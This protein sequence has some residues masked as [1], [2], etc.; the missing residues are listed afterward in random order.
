MISSLNKPA[1]S[2]R[3]GPWEASMQQSNKMNGVADGAYRLNIDRLEVLNERM[4]ERNVPSSILQQQFSQ[5]PVSTKYSILPMVDKYK[6]SNVPIDTQPIYKQ[7][8]VFNPGTSAPFNGYVNAV[9]DE[10]RLRNQFFALQKCEQSVYV[11]SSQSDLYTVNI[12]PNP[13]HQN[14]YG[15]TQ[16]DNHSLL[17]NEEEFIQFNPN[18]FH[19]GGNLFDNH[20]R[21]QLKGMSDSGSKT[22]R[23]IRLGNNT[24][25]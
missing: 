25:M 15:G 21:Q 23:N 18:L 8:D 6:E 24:F 19:L 13:S 1:S 4:F 17:F 12:P 16:D 14:S 22:L 11:P 7:K 9:N 10:S 3:N 2:S 5:R 20:T